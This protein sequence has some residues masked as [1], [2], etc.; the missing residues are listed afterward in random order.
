MKMSDWLA[1]KVAG[2][3]YVAQKVAGITYE[4]KAEV[5]RELRQ[6]RYESKWFL[7]NLMP[8]GHYFGPECEVC[9]KSLQLAFEAKKQ[10]IFGDHMELHLTY[11]EV[12]CG[13]C[14]IHL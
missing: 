3:T 9:G 14:G 6:R 8:F 10:S 4:E 11:L 13:S 7:E 12:S 2:I 1:Q 5:E